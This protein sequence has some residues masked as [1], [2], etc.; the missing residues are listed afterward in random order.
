MS[1]LTLQYRT[2]VATIGIGLLAGC[3]Q[4]ASPPAHVAAMP[5]AHASSSHSA[6]EGPRVA[7][8]WYQVYFD[9][10][11]TELNARGQLIIQTVANMVRN[12]S[13][14]RVSVVGKTDRVGGAGS[15][16]VLSEQRAE[17]VRD[18]LI[19]HAVPVARIDTSW[20]GEGRPEVA[21]PDNTAER[22]NRVVDITVQHSY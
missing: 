18:A 8:D 22:R 9:S 17:V 14:V 20:T 7:G 4:N 21:T 5:P 11:G 1:R 15:N 10:D 2:L 6:N 19:A 16:V 13:L 3:A 12:D